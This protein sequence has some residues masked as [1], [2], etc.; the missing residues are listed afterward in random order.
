MEEFVTSPFAQTTLVTI[1]RFLHIIFGVIW[2]G[3]GTLL[4]WLMIPT[5]QRMGERGSTMLRTFVGYSPVGTIIGVSALV[6][7]LAG[8]L[9]WPFRVQGAIDFRAFTGTGDIVMAIGA[10]F[11]LLAFGHGATATGRYTGVYA[12]AAKAYDDDPSD[13]NRAALDDAYSKMKLHAN[14]SA[15]LTVIAVV[16]M[17]GARY[18]G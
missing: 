1:F 16:C 18:L 12:A 17:S 3:F 8:L 10:V 4:A 5:A 2:V 14:V 6:T 15:W 11:G 7:T 9:L 13:A